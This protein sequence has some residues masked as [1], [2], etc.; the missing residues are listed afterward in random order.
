MGGS[1]FFLLTRLRFQACPDGLHMTGTLLALLVSSD[2]ITYIEVARSSF[3][4]IFASATILFWSMVSF[5]FSLYYW[6]P[7]TTWDVPCW[8][9]WVLFR[10]W[11]IYS[12]DYVNQ[13]FLAH[14]ILL[15]VA[16]AEADPWDQGLP[17]YCYKE[18]CSLCE[19]QE[20]QRCCEVQGAL[21]QVPAHPLCLRLFDTEKANK[22]KQSLPPS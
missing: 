2:L 21:L 6:L 7:D 15:L 17:P 10:Q 13:N 9:E 16:S 18:G 3:Y 1:A 14:V 20:E 22:L 12:M 8:A 5:L 4:E 11:F 19:N